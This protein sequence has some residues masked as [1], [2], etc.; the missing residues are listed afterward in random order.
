MSKTEGP[1]SSRLFNLNLLKQLRFY[2]TANGFEDTIN[3]RVIV[4]WDDVML[5]LQHRYPE[6]PELKILTGTFLLDELLNYP[7]PQTFLALQLNV[8]YHKNVVR[9]FRSAR[10]AKKTEQDCVDITFGL[11]LKLLELYPETVQQ[12]LMDKLTEFIA[13]MAE[14]K[15]AQYINQQILRFYKHKYLEWE[16]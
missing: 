9:W 2:L 11:G 12:L 3:R 6:A 13:D 14:K 1:D 10:E 5:C 16:R 7:K 15:D 8:D 4:L